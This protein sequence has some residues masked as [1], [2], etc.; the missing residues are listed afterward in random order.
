M[1]KERFIQHQVQS[2]IQEEEGFDLLSMGKPKARDVI[3]M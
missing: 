2:A 3:A 1:T